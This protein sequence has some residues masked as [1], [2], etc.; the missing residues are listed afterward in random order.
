VSRN[1]PR[2][3]DVTGRAHLAG[4]VDQTGGDHGLHGHAAVLVL[5]QHGI[6]D[7]VLIWSQILSG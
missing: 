7:R 1:N 6:E 2:D 4:D 3:V 5:G